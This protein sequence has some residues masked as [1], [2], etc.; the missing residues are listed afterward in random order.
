MGRYAKARDPGDLLPL[1]SRSLELRAF[2]FIH[3]REAVHHH[4]VRHR[5]RLHDGAVP[6]DAQALP[7][8][9]LQH[10]RPHR[11]NLI[12]A[13]ASFG[14]STV[15]RY[16]KQ[17]LSRHAFPEL[18]FDN[19]APRRRGYLS[20]LHRSTFLHNFKLNLTFQE[21]FTILF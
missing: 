14:E 10:D 4:G 17:T 6:D 11:V 1:C 5:L 18:R 13:D 8:W 7:S 9:S 20:N 3:G 19:A 21:T 16:N 2:T 15:T 12:A